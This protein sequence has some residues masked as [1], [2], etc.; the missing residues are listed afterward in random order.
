MFFYEFLFCPRTPQKVTEAAIAAKIKPLRSETKSPVRQSDRKWTAIDKPAALPTRQSPKTRSNATIPATTAAPEK[1]TPVSNE[2]KFT[3][4]SV[5]KQQT[6]TQWVTKKSPA[7][8]ADTK[9]VATKK[10]IS[11]RSGKPSPSGN[12]WSDSLICQNE[13]NYFLSAAPIK[14]APGVPPKKSPATGKL[15]TNKAAVE[16]KSPTQSLKIGDK[17]VEVKQI[18]MTKTQIEDMKKQGKIQMKDGRLC[19]FKK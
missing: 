3:P 12:H 6:L 2:K 16:T 10:I 8:A 11:T 19:I 1:K 15:P 13:C 14:P 4:P 5:E 7:V 17:M 18:R 9:E